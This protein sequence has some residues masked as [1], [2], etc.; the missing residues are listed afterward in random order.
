MTEEEGEKDNAGNFCG[1]T[2]GKIRSKCASRLRSN[3]K[4]WHGK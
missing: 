3:N 2:G 4:G 1:M